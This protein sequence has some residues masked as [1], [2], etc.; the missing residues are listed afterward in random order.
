MALNPKFSDTAANAA[1]NAI[2]ALCNTGDLKIYDGTQPTNANTA[3][4]A[5]VL[6]ATLT[7]NA[8]AFGG[9]S[10]G[11]CTA[12]AIVSATAVATST[13]TWFRVLKS[14]HA[15]VVF[16]GSVGTATANLILNAVAIV[17]GATVSVSAFTLT[18]TE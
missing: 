15:T 3:I 11:V 8:T 17:T 2:A 18:A 10:A 16:D 5:Q 9:A 7:F 14:D 6:L 1:A 4:G 12:N 13:A